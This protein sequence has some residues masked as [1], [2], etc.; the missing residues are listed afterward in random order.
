LQPKFRQKVN[1]L[2]KGTKYRYNCATY[3]CAGTGFG[4]DLQIGRLFVAIWFVF[5]IASIYL[6]T[7]SSVYTSRLSH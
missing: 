4:Q 5:R 1:L 6:N 3:S 2:M 7:W